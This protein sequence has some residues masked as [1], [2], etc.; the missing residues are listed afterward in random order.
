MA[1]ATDE[2]RPHKRL[3]LSRFM[4]V[5]ML[6]YVDMELYAEL[7]IM[8][9]STGVIAATYAK[10]QC[11]ITATLNQYR[12]CHLHPVLLLEVRH[13]TAL[14]AMCPT[15]SEK[16]ALELFGKAKLY[17]Q[18]NASTRFKRDGDIERKTWLGKKLLSMYRPKPT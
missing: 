4:D 3:E 8:V 15:N 17:K 12:I 5:K 11:Q 6:P 16:R 2:V 1:F 14:A 10:L 18:M 9:M 13:W 7:K